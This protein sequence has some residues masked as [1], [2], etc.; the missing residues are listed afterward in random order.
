MTADAAEI[1]IT[2]AGEADLPALARLSVQLAAALGGSQTPEVARGR[3]ASHLRHG[4]RVAAFRSGEAIIGY[5]LWLDLGDHVFLRQFV[6]DAPLRGR[7]L[8]RALFE[9]LAA[10]VFPPRREIR[11]DV[12]HG[13]PVGFWSALGFATKTTG[14]R[15]APDPEEA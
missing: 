6:I 8:G 12:L 1:V 2:P 13:G 14:M 9:R 10:E 11:L 4:Y 7:G 3:F 15:R 5:A